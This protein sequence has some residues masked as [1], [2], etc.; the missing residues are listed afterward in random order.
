MS[1]FWG[2]YQ[3]IFGDLTYTI[4]F[5]TELLTTGI[6]TIAAGGKRDLDKAPKAA[7]E[8]FTVSKGNI[9]VRFLE[10]NNRDATAE[11]TE[12]GE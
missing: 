8:V 2:S 4:Y 10:S 9:V 11:D 12:V 6:A 7:E 3:G 1:K 5:D